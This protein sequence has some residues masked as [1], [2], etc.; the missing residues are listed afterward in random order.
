MLGVLRHSGGALEPRAPQPGV[1][2]LYALIQGA[3][4][5][6]KAVELTVEGEPGT[7]A[8]GIELGLYRLLETSLAST[9]SARPGVSLRFGPDDIELELRQDGAATPA[10]PLQLM[11]ER[12]WLCDG[13]VLSRPDESEFIARLPRGSE[14]A[15]A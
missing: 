12:V 15:F 4:D 3:R 14:P 13:D 1:D 10:W 5:A 7:L 6:G 9:A 11:R 2:Q 8:A